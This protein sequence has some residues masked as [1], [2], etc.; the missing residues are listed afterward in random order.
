[1]VREDPRGEP[2]WQPVGA[3]EMMTAVVAEQLAANREQLE[4]L[5]P[6]RLTPHLLDDH[7]VNRI[8]D[9]F[10]VQREDMWLWQEPGGAGRPRR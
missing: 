1:M 7:T 2:N 4:T 6:A 5:G 3:V 8:K 9:V 10:G